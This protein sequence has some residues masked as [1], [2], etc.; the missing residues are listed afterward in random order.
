MRRSHRALTDQSARFDRRLL[1]LAVLRALTVDGDPGAGGGGGAPAANSGAPGAAPAAGA[2]PAA[3]AAAAAPKPDASIIAAPDKN[4][5]PSA[6]DMRKYLV[7]KGGKADELGK[8]AEADLQ[9]RYTEAKGKE[10]QPATVKAEDIKVSIPDGITIDEKTLGEFKGLLV[11]A[12]LS[13]QDR[14]QKLVDL[15]VG[16]LRAAA[17]APHQLWTKTQGE[18]QATVKADKELGG[19]NFDA[20]RATITKGI[21]AVFGKDTQSADAAFE[22]F[23]YTG[24][25]NHPALVRLMYRVGKMLSEGDPVNGGAPAD[26]KGKD[27]SSRV[28]AMYPSANNGAAKA[29]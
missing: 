23:A 19:Q 13:P 7:E 28:A 2:D 1:D 20:T 11:D 29:A 24:A 8:L 25:G 22:A 21:Q 6:D 3:A 9:K 14:A 18:W 12:K 16:A 10:G 15:H 17:D 27:F 5:Q 26:G 4:A